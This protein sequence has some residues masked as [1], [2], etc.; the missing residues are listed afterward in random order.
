M[1]MLED[2][3]AYLQQTGVVT[4]AQNCFVGEIPEGIHTAA[5][6]RQ[7]SG[8]P[9]DR[10]AN[11]IRPGLQVVVRTSAYA[12][13]LTLATSIFNKLYLIGDELSGEPDSLPAG[14]EIGGTKY[15]R[16]DTLETPFD[17]GTTGAG[18]REFIFNSIVY[19]L[20]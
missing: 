12:Q 14:V 9:P 1:P 20:K 7:Y 6:L 4:M 19:I 10:M 17:N 2:I 3:G 5:M 8:I 13:G 16:V 15:L 18:Q 11:S